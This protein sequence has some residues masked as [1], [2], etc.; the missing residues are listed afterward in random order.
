MSTMLNDP[1]LIKDEAGGPVSSLLRRLGRADLGSLP[2]ILGLIVIW[3]IFRI[4]NPN[5]LTPLNLT[6]LMLQIAA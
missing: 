3:T 6:N 2:V 1:R 5:F 4:A